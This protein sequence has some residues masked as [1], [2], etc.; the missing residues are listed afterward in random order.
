[1]CIFDV[2]KINLASIENFGFSCFTITNLNGEKLYL[3]E[4]DAN[5]LVLSPKICGKLFKKLHGRFYVFETNWEPTTTHS[6]ASIVSNQIFKGF[7]SFSSNNDVEKLEYFF[8]NFHYNY[9]LQMAFYPI[10]C[11]L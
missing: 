5:R 6:R 1:M 3:I 2:Q 8:F 10:D 9:R 7:C 11:D 4:K